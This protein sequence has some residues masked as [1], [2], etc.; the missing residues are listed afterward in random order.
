[1]NRLVLGMCVAVGCALGSSAPVASAPTLSSPDSKQESAPER[2][3]GRRF[4]PFKPEATTSTGSVTID[5]RAISYQAVAGTLVI[6]PKD[7]DDVPRDPN[8]EKPTPGGSEDSADS[9]NPTAVAS[10]FYVAYFKEAGG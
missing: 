3:E 10:M 5:G 2:P 9:K 4:E 7:W 6:H 8:T 1:M